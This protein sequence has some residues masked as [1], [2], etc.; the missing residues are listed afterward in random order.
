MDSVGEHLYHTLVLE[1]HT[2]TQ[3]VAGTVLYGLPT[4]E[5]LQYTGEPHTSTTIDYSV[6]KRNT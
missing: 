3:R 2:G 4:V 5:A 1:H 6:V